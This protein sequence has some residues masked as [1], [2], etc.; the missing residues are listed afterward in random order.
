[1]IRMQRIVLFA[2]CMGM[3]LLPAFAQHAHH[4]APPAAPTATNTPADVVSP[5]ASPPARSTD[6]D[7]DAHTHHAPTAT[8][9]PD[10]N[11]AGHQPASSAP[12][13]H[14]L[15][16]P[17]AVEL[18]AAFPDLHGMDMSAHMKEDPLIATLA[19]DQLEQRHGDDGDRQAWELHGWWGNSRD[20]LWLRSGGSVHD[21]RID[22]AHAELLWGRPTGPWWDALVGIRHDS[23]SGPDRHWLA[24][25]VQ[26][27]APYKFE[28]AATGYLGPS[29]RT[30][31]AVQA[32]YELLLTNRLI[33]QPLAEVHVYGRSD[34]ANG[35]GSGIATLDTGL[36][37]RYE[38][39]RQF[40]PYIGITSERSI[41]N[42]AQLRRDAGLPRSDTQWLAGLR[43]WF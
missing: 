43:I 27:L 28:V 36:R 5:P 29:G 18:A 41:G 17:S 13:T 11:R 3:P 33:L 10:D 31:L 2:M 40:A 21:G 30:A 37:L 1:M 24:F 34:P 8:T 4:P 20:K 23:G 25:G 26:G 32:E 14:D 12:I 6:A 9:P 16:A 15:P 35:I 38:I 7:G 22:H 19:F 39:T 42:T